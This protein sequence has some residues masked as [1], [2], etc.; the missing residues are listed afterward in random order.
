MDAAAHWRPVIAV[1]AN[2]ETRRV[3]AKLM[4]GG[5]LEDATAALPAAK[6][7]RVAAALTQSGLIEPGSQVFAPGVFRAILAAAPVPKREGIDRFVDGTRIR[8]FPTNAEE[9]V[10]LLAWVADGAFAAGEVLTERE[11]TQRLLPYTADVARLRRSLVDHGLVER[12]RDG[13][14]YARA[15]TG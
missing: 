14:E 1:L 7:R 12:R 4:L 2:P 15:G 11:V 9:R 6:R 3:A 8:Q 5:T 10:R 13:T